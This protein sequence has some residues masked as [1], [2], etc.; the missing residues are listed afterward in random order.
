MDGVVH[1]A[2]FDSLALEPGG[3]AT[4]STDT[5]GHELSGRARR[6]PLPW[7]L[8]CDRD[9]QPERPPLIDSGRTAAPSRQALLSALSIARRISCC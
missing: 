1:A 9:R 4:A 3:D 8:V 7:G 2:L 6:L 5:R